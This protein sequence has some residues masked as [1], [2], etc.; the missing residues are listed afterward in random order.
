MNDMTI[1]AY[2][3][4]PAKNQN[5]EPATPTSRSVLHFVFILFHSFLFHFIFF[6]FFF[7]D[8][9]HLKN[10]SGTESGQES[11][12]QKA[13]PRSWCDSLKSFSFFG[14]SSALRQLCLT[15]SIKEDV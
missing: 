6:F 11:D 5:G 2:T 9:L 13:S 7:V 10:Q 15:P 1:L 8:A 12:N 14:G 4:Q 3:Q